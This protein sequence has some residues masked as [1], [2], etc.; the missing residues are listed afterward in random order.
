MTQK[1]KN[2]TSLTDFIDQHIGT[3]GSEARQA[4]DAGYEVFKLGFLLQQ[5]R[6][7]KGLTQEELANNI[8]SNKSYVSKIERDTKD[9]RLSTLQRIVEEGLGGK[10][11][12]SIEF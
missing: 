4:H 12:I 9:I 7:Q 11:K 2:L 6:L 3:E 5:A 8:G 10:V 1:D